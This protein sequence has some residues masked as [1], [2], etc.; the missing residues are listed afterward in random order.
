MQEKKLLIFCVIGALAGIGL[1]F[2]LTTNL[3]FTEIKN[4]GKESVGKSLKIQGEITGFFISDKGHVFLKISDKTAEISAVIFNSSSSKIGAYNLK[5]GQNVEVSGKIDE[6]N[7]K[8]E[9]M[10]KEINVKS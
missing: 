1:L 7:G 4:I 10:P 6:Y 8:L 9:I 5:K 2:F 3:P